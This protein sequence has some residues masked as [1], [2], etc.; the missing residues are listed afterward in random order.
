VPRRPGGWP[1]VALVSVVRLRLGDLHALA[2][3][4]AGG[5]LGEGFLGTS[6]QAQQPLLA[7]YM[8]GSLGQYCTLAGDPAYG[9]RLLRDAAGR[10]P[11]RAPAAAR[12]WLASLESV[13]FGYLGDR[14]ALKAI[15]D[16][17]RYAEASAAAEPVWPW[18]FKFGADKV[19][20]YKAVAASRL[21][22][23]KIAAEAFAQAETARSPK[24][25]ALVAIEHARALA[26]GGDLD[27]ALALAV[28][29]YDIGSGY[30]SE[31]VCQAVRE[32]R[33]SISAQPAGSR[34]TSELDDRLHRAYTPRTA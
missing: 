8:Q 27:Q 28:T 15:D 10:L 4:E 26:T 21:G 11:H 17:Q 18:V 24:Q 32:F 1:G 14:S 16:A 5:E 9:L 23:P 22:L 12:V 31:R 29:A 2:L 19:A 30:E 3:L 25:A 7:I 33:A 13:A 20:S 6:R 34:L